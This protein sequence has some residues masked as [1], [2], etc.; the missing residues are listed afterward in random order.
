MNDEVVA[1]IKNIPPDTYLR[2]SYTHSNGGLSGMDQ[3]W[4]K[5][6]NFEAKT[7]TLKSANYDT[8]KTVWIDNIKSPRDIDD[9]YTGSGS[10]GPAIDEISYWD[11][12]SG[13][14]TVHM[15]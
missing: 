8:L 4:L 6:V 15:G 7:L 9:T 11:R 14:L 13:W 5:G 12:V 10:A 3:G 2:I 1:R